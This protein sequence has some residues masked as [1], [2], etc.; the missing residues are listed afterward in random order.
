M[1]PHYY[2]HLL[3]RWHKIFQGNKSVKKYVNEFDEFLNRYYILG[4]QSDVQVFSQFCTGLRI[5]L[6]HELCKHGIIE[7]K[8]AY[9]LVQ[10]L[11][12]PKLSHIF[13]SQNHPPQH[14]SRLRVSIH[15]KFIHRDQYTRWISTTKVL[16]EC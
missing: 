10:D 12:V 3:D 16:K 15:T 14:S 7:F 4:K 13:R 8:G 9:A 11:D 2:K 5:D 6:E 1:P